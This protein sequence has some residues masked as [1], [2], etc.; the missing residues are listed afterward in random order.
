VHA[1]LLG[2]DDPSANDL[3]FDKPKLQQRQNHPLCYG[4][5]PEEV[6]VDWKTVQLIFFK[7]QCG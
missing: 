5:N 3:S 1:L 2:A 4:S 7:D 6:I